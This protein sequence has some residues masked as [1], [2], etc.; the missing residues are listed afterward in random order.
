MKLINNQD[1]LLLAELKHVISSQSEILI[2]SGYLT[3]PAIFELLE[4]FTQV[5]SIKVLVDGSIESDLRFVYDESE[6]QNYF[7]LDTSYKAKKVIKLVEDKFQIRSGNAGGQ[8][9]ILVINPDQS[10]CFSIVPQNLNLLTLGVEAVNSPIILTYFDDTLGQYKGLFEQFWNISNKDIKGSFVD[11]LKNRFKD[12]SPEFLYKYTLYQIFQNS[13]INDENDKRINQIG[14]KQTE[15]WKYLFNFQ[16]DAVLGGIDKIETYG[17]CIIADSVGLGKTFEALAIMK[18]Y[19][20]RND[21][22]LVLC[23]KKLRDNWLIYSQNDV[24]NIL[25]KDRLNFDV[26][27]HTDLSRKSG[28]SGDINL[29]TI[30]WGNY[31]LIV[32]DESH[33]FRNNNP[34]RDGI[35]RY[36]RLMNDIIKS[37]VKTKVLMLSATPVNTR[38]NDIKNQI[39][40]ITEQQDTAL[41]PFGIKSIEQTLRKA[42]TRFNNWLRDSNGETSNRDALINGLD[43]DYFKLLDLLTIARSRKHI[44]KYY[45]VVDIGKFP[46]RLDPISKNTD[47]DTNG[48]FQS[49]DKV[50]DELNALNLGF[51]SPL[52]Y[53]R[54]DKREAYEKKYDITTS[55]GS[56]FKQIERENSLIHLMRVNLLKRLESSIY[57]FRLTLQALLTKIDSLLEKIDNVNRL[58]YFDEDLDINNIDTDDDM[59]EDLIAGG[60]VKVLLQDMDLI[61]CREDLIDDRKRLEDL[62]QQTLVID[63]SR[64]AKLQE[65]KKLIKHKVEN[66]I[67]PNNKKVIVF[68]AFADTARYLYEKLSGWIKED[69]NLHSALVTGGDGNKVNMNGCK[70]DLSS[71]LTHFSPISK[72]RDII[73]PGAREE[74]DI[75]FCTDCISEGQNLQDCDY[76]VNFDIHWNPVRIIQRFGRIDRI[77]SKNDQIQLVNFFPN[78]ALDTYI[79][80]IARVKG[81]MQMLDVSAT[82]DDN[83][84]EETSA[85]HHDLDYRRRQLKQ[86][87]SR[88]L[89]LE[90]IEGGISITDLTFND[91]KIDAERLSNEERTD[92]ELTPK[93]IFSI[94][95]KNLEET[96][97]GVIFCIKD[98]EEDPTERPYFSATHPYHLCFI[99]SDGEIFVPANNPKKSLDYYKK[100]CLGKKEVLSEL[101]DTFNRETRQGKNMEEYKELLQIAMEHVQGVEEEVGLDSL[102]HAGGTMMNLFQKNQSFEI[103]SYLIVK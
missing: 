96:P 30:N 32:I 36:Q 35:T 31:D 22:I 53:V 102:A 66:N 101:M 39:A 37:G 95:D 69:L 48:R 16:K 82:G 12:K 2:A 60:K 97:S 46:T 57:S 14:F 3:V 55:T 44:E 21:R 62:L 6:Y 63:E 92:M 99:S 98:L 68:S 18:Y 76:L 58:G 23:P 29:E 50:N 27:N 93:S 13:V 43:G 17:G 52:S 74:I 56:I 80:L 77:G 54:G 88:V 61:R 94:T 7:N 103:V 86:L 87:Q 38:M 45:D 28:F 67:N 47:F 51:Y 72:K 89:D 34:K 41:E 78:L 10:H 19:Q 90:D 85:Q 26:L 9:F 64:D 11:M 42:Q 4:E 1:T 5:K 71:I 75:L 83:I 15:I 49:M 25:S 8:K 81:R 79:D 91:F 70:S 59:L 40:F 73:F 33:N 65:L 100:L 24:R 20:M 84:I